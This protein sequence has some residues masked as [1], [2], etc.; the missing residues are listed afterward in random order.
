MNKMHYISY[1]GSNI[2]VLKNPISFIS[3]SRPELLKS[4][5]G[6][7][8]FLWE[9]NPF[10]KTRSFSSAYTYVIFFFA[11]TKGFIQGRKRIFQRNSYDLHHLIFEKFIGFWRS[12][13]RFRSFTPNSGIKPRVLGLSARDWTW[14]CHLNFA[15]RRVLVWWMVFG[16]VRNHLKCF[17]TLRVFL[18]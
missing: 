2:H 6:S 13:P 12:E 18:F 1:F 9:Q 7:F 16:C 10:Y 11:G 17:A 4:S 15:T 14:L 8:F 5:K 3:M